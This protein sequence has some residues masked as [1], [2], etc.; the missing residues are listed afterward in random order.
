MSVIASRPV[1]AGEFPRRGV[2]SFNPVGRIDR[3]LQPASRPSTG[4]DSAPVDIGQP[5]LRVFAAGIVRCGAIRPTSSLKLTVSS[6]ASQTWRARRQVYA[7]VQND[8][9]RRFGEIRWDDETLGGRP[10]FGWADDS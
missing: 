7:H 1:G 8:R 6:R 4:R 2:G 9:V 10:L 3:L 5:P